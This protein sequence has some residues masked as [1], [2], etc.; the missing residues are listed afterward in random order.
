MEGLRKTKEKFRQDIRYPDQ[1]LNPGPR[2]YE[3]VMLEA[4]K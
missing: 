2:E 1:D 3:A 4:Q